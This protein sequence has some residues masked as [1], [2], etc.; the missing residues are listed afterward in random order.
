VESSIREHSGRAQRAIQ[1]TVDQLGWAIN[2][3]F[4]GL[5]DDSLLHEAEELAD[6][7]VLACTRARLSRAARAAR[8][9]QSLMKLAPEDVYSMRETFHHKLFELLGLVRVLTDTDSDAGAAGPASPPSEQSSG[10]R[11]RPVR[12]RP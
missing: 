8:A 5:R 4:K 1:E 12:A 11:S 6:R 3:L 7:L 2:R 10:L 9:L